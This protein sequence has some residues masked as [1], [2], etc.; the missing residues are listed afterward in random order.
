MTKNPL[1][2]IPEEMRD[3]AEKSVD[4]ARKA[5]ETFVGAAVKATEQADG[6]TEQ[7]RTMAMEAAATAIKQ[8]ES[9]VAAAFELAQS[10]ARAKDI[11]EILS[12]QRDFVKNQMA[13]FEKQVS[14]ATQQFQERAKKGL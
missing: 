14:A 4:Q 8:A 9:N 7:A 1:Y 3:F 2:E 6:A 11:N 12:A 13:S 10:L 5:F